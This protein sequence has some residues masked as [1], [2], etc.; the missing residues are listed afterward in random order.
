MGCGGAMMSP[1]SIEVEVEGKFW[2]G[3]P[4]GMYAMFPP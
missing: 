1:E 3:Y 4:V 2:Y